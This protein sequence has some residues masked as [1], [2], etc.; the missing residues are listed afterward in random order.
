M[1]III[2][3]KLNSLYIFLYSDFGFWRNEKGECEYSDRHPDR[4]TVCKPGDKFRGRSGYK[5]NSKSTCSGGIDLTKEKEWECGES[6]QVHV[7]KTVFS[8]KV[9]DYL[10]FTDTN[11]VFV[12]TAD[13]K[14]WRSDNDGYEWKQILEGNQIIAMY[15]NP[16]H[17]QN[18]YFITNTRILFLT[19]DRGSNIIERTTPLPPIQNLVGTILNFHRD[20]SDYLLFIGED[21]CDSLFSNECHSEAFYS[22]NNGQTWNSIGTYIRGCIWGRDGAIQ[23]ADHDTILCEVYREKSGNQRNFFA[24]PLQFVSSDNYFESMQYLFEDM[25]GVAIF[26]KFMVVAVSQHGGAN[27]Q[28]HVSMDGKTFAPAQFPASF[29]VSPEAFTIMESS[30]NMWI[31]VS[32]NTHK[33]S[34]YGNIFTSNSNG[35]YFVPSLNYANRNEMGIVD[36]EKMQ[37][38]EGIALANQVSNS[39]QANMG[40]PKKLVTKMTV[41]AGRSWIS[42]TPPNMDSKKEYFSCKEDCALHLHSY[43]ERRN[44]RDLF[45]TS[46]AVGLMVGVGNVGS[47]LTPYRDGDMFLTRDAGKT[48]NEVYK[49]AHIW[50]FADQ[51]ALLILVDD[52]E[53]TNEL[54]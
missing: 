8:D 39:N 14:V 10:Y 48:W 25:V 12:R 43:S 36:F 16:H 50:E 17:E 18:A 31:H 52:E 32:T 42:L 13:N 26:G 37:G 15:Q 4:P 11:R 22:H 40:D 34:E 41:D 53:E 19:E 45:S 6:G 5:K 3:K 27:L 44:T 20:E 28:L 1:I 51:G 54:K 23:Y 30:N 2:I 33:G 38:I 29:T 46:S 9:V 35:T 21:R 49:G 24:N 47:H 7:T